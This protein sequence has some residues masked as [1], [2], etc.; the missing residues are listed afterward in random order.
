MLNA[1]NQV[2]KSTSQIVKVITLATNRSMWKRFWKTPPRQFWYLYPSQDVATSEF[3]NKWAPDF[4]PRGHYKDDPDESNDYHWVAHFEK[5]KITHITFPNTGVSIYFKV[6]SQAAI[7]LQ[8]ATCHYIAADE[9]MPV[10]LYDELQFRLAATEGYFSMVFTAT[11]GQDMWRYAMEPE[12]RGTDAEK[13]PQAHKWQISLFDCMKFEDGSDSNWTK[14][15]IESIISTCRDQTEVL[16]RVYGRFVQ[17]TGLKFPSFDQSKN[18][19]GKNWQLPEDW[20]IYAGLDYGSGGRQ[21]HPAAIVFVAVNHEFTKAVLFRAWR[22]DGVETTAEDVLVKYLSM[23]EDIKHRMVDSFYDYHCKDLFVIAQ[24]RAI[25]LIPANKKHDEGEQVLDSLFARKGLVIVENDETLKIVAEIKS[26][27]KG[28]DK[29]RSGDDLV[30]AL[31][32]C[33]IGIPWDWENMDGIRAK[34]SD[35]VL[36]ETEQRRAAF[37]EPEAKDWRAEEELDEWNDLFN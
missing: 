21:G 24:R 36:T 37:E 22:G 30:D 4:L 34:R 12:F 31:R 10:H 15:R 26:S 8:T 11:I 3:H 6:Y 35:R 23:R 13:F 28:T 5:R 27:V 25:N 18:F 16:K 33:V 7:N 29:R 20:M 1:A 17:D 9:E 19:I 32:Y 14:G 2:G